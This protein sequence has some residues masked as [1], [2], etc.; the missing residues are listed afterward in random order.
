MLNRK[1]ILLALGCTVLFGQLHAE[2]LTP[3]RLPSERPSYPLSTTIAQPQ[4]ATQA[5][6]SDNQGRE[7]YYKEFEIRVKSLSAPE[8]KK[9]ATSFSKKQRAAEAAGKYDEAQHY[10]RL[11]QILNEVGKK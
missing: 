2:E 6:P 4:P 5:Q 10:L 9:L 3:Y 1:I 7:A 11:Q 8:I